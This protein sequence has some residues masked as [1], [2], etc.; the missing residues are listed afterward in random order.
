MPTDTMN[1]DIAFVFDHAL[2][3]FC[4]DADGKRTWPQLFFAAPRGFRPLT[5]YL[6]TPAGDGPHPLF[7]H[8]HGGAWWAGHE[9]ISNKTLDAMK[10]TETLVSAGYAVA[11]ISYRLSGEAQF[12][13]PLHDCKAA[14]R[15][16][17]YH[18]AKLGL[19]PDRFAVY[20]ESASAHLALMAGLVQNDPEL[21]GD[22]GI[23]GVS[24][25][26]SCIV[27][28][29]GPTDLTGFVKTVTADPPVFANNDPEPVRCLLGMSALDNPECA[30]RASPVFHVTPQSPPVL[31]QH[32]TSDRVVPVSQA[33]TLAKRLS[34]QG[35]K[36]FLETIE[37]ADHCFW[38]VPPD[39]ILARILSF[40][41]E[42]L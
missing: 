38:G 6:T 22:V 11:R 9:N 40:L 25:A 26:V 14:I 24:S 18:A 42:N 31:I 15:Y 39:A 4:V 3:Q 1:E 35:V 32:G 5:M 36:H 37:G 8:I 34:E 2:N 29:Y 21:E 12:P 19:D 23:T 28:W 7:V 10:L 17:R 20:G 33:E 13:V 41:N 16:L 27:E 30:R